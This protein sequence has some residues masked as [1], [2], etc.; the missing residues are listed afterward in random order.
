MANVSYLV[1]TVNL[2]SFNPRSIKQALETV[3]I[4]RHELELDISIHED[5]LLVGQGVGRNAERI[6]SITFNQ[7][8]YLLNYERDIHYLKNAWRT[9][10]KDQELW[11]SYYENLASK[12]EELQR[13][14]PNLHQSAEISYGT[15]YPF[16]EFKV[17][18]EICYF[19]LDFFQAYWFDEGIHPDFIPPDYQRKPKPGKL[20]RI[21]RF[22]GF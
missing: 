6:T 9:R 5:L 4:P 21:S 19:L 2:Q 20:K 14:N 17:R 15:E 7:N 18:D 22:L 16:S 1:P 12:L 11:K 3:F 10:T 13:I 8:C